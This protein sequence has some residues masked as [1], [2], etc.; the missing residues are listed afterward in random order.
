MSDTPSINRRRLL[1]GIASA[2][3]AG[4]AIAISSSAVVAASE[5]GN[6][7]R[8]A[9]ELPTMEAR[10]IAARN[11][12]EAAYRSGMK[13]WPA[14]PKALFQSHYGSR[15]LERDVAGG[16]IKRNGDFSNIWELND[17]R[18]RVFA[19]HK[20]VHRPRKRPEQPFAIAFFTGTDTAEGWKLVLDEWQTK[21]I[22]AET[23]YSATERLRLESGYEQA[24][25]TDEAA[26]DAL[27]AHVASIMAE[28]PATM[29][30]IIA[31]AQALAT[32][33]KVE[34]FYR[35]CTPESW[36]WASCFADNVIRIAEDCQ[37]QA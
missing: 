23:Y 8:L 2:S 36:P 4:A 26:R 31:Q 20:A 11:A 30:G 9:D 28:A 7:L 14:A 21:L 25:L 6:L 5:N 24:R 3:A 13:R 29:A 27:V 10:Y 32:F 16:A 1:L 15:S 33:G 19:L 35:V 17:I 22:A 37:A 12:K 18:N 34:K